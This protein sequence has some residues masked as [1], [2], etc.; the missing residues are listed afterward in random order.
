MNSTPKR[1]ATL[2]L[3]AGLAGCAADQIHRD[4]LAAIDRGAYEEGVAK[5][6]Q[7]VKNEPSNLEFRLDLRA[8]KE[9]AVQKLIADADNAR[10]AGRAEDARVSYRR[11]LVIEPG[12]ERARRGLEGVDANKRHAER[13]AKA[14]QL[15]ATHQLD[16][17]DAE[18]RAVLAEDPGFTP[19]IAAAGKIDVARGPINVSPRLHGADSRPVT[20]QFRDAPT[21]MVFEVLARQTGINFIFDKDVKSD[22][23]TTIFV[24]QVPVESAIDLILTQN[25]LARQ[26]LS[27]NMV[28]VYPNTAAKQKDYL[29]EI[30]HTFYL[31]NAAPKDAESMLKTVLGAKTLYVDERSSTV[32][33]RDTPEHIRMAEKLIASLDV[34]EPEVMLEVEVVEI[35]R[36]LADQIGISYPA[37]VS[38]NISVPNSTGTGTGTIGTTS[39]LSPVPLT[40]LNHINPST[41]LISGSSLKAGLDLTKTTSLGNVLASP[42]IRAKNKEKAKILIGDRVPVITQGTTS[43]VGGAFSTSNVQYLEVGLSLDV[44]P[45]IHLDGNVG[46]K[47]GLE[48]SSIT[49]TVNVGSTTAYKIGTR[50]ANTTLELKDGETQVLAGLIQDSDRRTSSH[51]PGLGDLP[52]LGHL[53]GTKG[54][55]IDKNEIVLSITPRIIRAQSRPSS[56]MTEFWYG[57]ESGTRAAPLASGAAYVAPTGGTGNSATTGGGLSFQSAGA[58]SLQAPPP[59]APHAAPAQ[60]A[61][62]VVAP[63]AASEAGAERTADAAPQAPPGKPVITTEGPDSAKVGEEIEVALKLSSAEA[64]GRVRAQVRF[65]ASALQ[66]VSAEPGDLGSSG[67]S[68]K[69]DLKPG[70]VQLEL[71]GTADAPV[72]GGGTLLRMRFKVV[73]A[74]PVSISSQVVLVGADGVA[75]ASTPSTPLKLAVT[76]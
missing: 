70:G 66:L 27:E 36:S 34:S 65:D 56:D 35:T 40:T 16:Q 64:L 37:G 28:L 18:V 32:V 42:R 72:A 14:E 21:K 62:S 50:N 38:A 53:F 48:V 43:T 31:T 49:D 4:G 15:L 75:I 10:A 26:V 13:V 52:I 58:S 55:S 46:I 45:T 20:L 30:V 63:A 51:I 12:N 2:L 17:A 57:T 47:L 19:A 69:V 22:S 23:K 67:D 59:A 54:R 5:L 44:T 71:A 25:Q 74:R 29:D 33:M 24:S 7:A 9:A 68:P 60:L 3:L 73:A 8:R 41:I 6:E 11:V 39:S 61:S 76:Q 1:M